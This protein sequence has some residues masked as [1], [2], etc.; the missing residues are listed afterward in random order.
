M[1]INLKIPLYNTPHACMDYSFLSCRLKNMKTPPPSMSIR[2]VVLPTSLTWKILG[3]RP[4]TRSRPRLPWQPR[5]RGT[6]EWAGGLRAT[7]LWRNHGKTFSVPPPDMG[8]KRVSFAQ[9][10]LYFSYFVI[11]VGPS[12]TSWYFQLGQILKREILCL[13]MIESSIL[14]EISNPPK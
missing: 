10:F 12:L 14:L 3:A 4:G 8:R 13:K 6:T 7:R 1:K 9:A 2:V 5:G 11:H